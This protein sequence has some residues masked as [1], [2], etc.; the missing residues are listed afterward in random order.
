M[1]LC[2]GWAC[3]FVARFCGVVPGKAVGVLCVFVA[4]GVFG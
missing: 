3:F 2:A 1:S 4:A